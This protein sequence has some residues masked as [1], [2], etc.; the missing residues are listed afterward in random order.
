MRHAGLVG[1]LVLAA[2][3]G[4]LGAA[5]AARAHPLGNFSVNHVA[6]VAISSDAV[7]VRYVLDLAEVPT[8]QERR[9]ADPASV[10]RK[11]ARVERD[12][13]LLV[14]G[15]RVA[16]TATG[17][18]RL[19]KPEGQGGLRTT[20]F[21][22]DLRAAVA[23]PH[24][25]EVRDG[26]FAGRVGWRAIVVAPGSGTA[27][28][29]SDAFTGDPTD[30]LRRYPEA[31]R[32]SPLDQRAASFVVTPGRGTVEAP[33]GPGAASAEVGASRGDGGFAGVFAN[34][35]AGEGV[36]L[37]LLL[38]AFAWGAAHALSPGHGKV[39]V[40]AYLVGARGTARD[41][42]AL[43]A[44][45]TVTH[46]IGVFALGAVTL[47]LSQYVLPETLYPYLNL[48]AGLLVIVI[49]LGALRSRAR[50]GHSHGHSHGHDGHHHAQG[51]DHEHQ[52]AH[53]H[54]HDGH[55]HHHGPESH[56]HSHGGAAHS[57]LPPE[58]LTGRGLL[59]MGAAAGLIPCPSALVVLLGA[60]AQQQ[61]A[62]GLLL[63]TAFSLG[64]AGT[65]T[66]LG[67]AVVH[68]KA[69]L[70]SG[71]SGKLVAALP[72]ASALVILLAGV[73]LTLRAVPTLS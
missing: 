61:I 71:R 28:R 65:L 20:R 51:R 10:A 22:L 57:H 29:T 56:V 36:L 6:R 5:P 12:L 44:I 15:R 45:V 13:E 46:T 38:A 25:V 27:V 35:A 47:V 11:T 33:P 67:L 3:A 31:L 70:P 50:R 18:G 48:T 8:F 69:R 72:V 43:G 58:R 17:P 53:S 73:L 16:L 4:L 60:I 14:D 40:A 9:L 19:T 34:A 52:H 2:L 42:V 21:E 24:S 66:V 59:G 54:G 30:G 7:D 62:L 64:L 32:E 63:I 39:M 23:D 37:F 55:H 26:T 41:A 49:G 1:L 68:T